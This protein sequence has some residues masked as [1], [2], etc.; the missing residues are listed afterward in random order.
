MRTWG[1]LFTGRQTLAL[2]TYAK[3]VRTYVDQF[4]TKDER[5]KGALESVLA[6]LV[7][8]LADLNASVCGWQLNTANSA[9]VFVR[10]ALPMVFDFA[11]VNPLAAAGGSPESAIRRIEACID[12]LISVFERKWQAL[13]RFQQTRGVSG[14]DGI[15]QL[16]FTR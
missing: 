11:E 3:L 5:L 4:T 2:L 16:A 12:N 7:N 9:H 1:D 15:L 13:P 8:R 14:R 10:W 6:L